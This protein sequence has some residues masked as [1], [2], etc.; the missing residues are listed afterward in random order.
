MP[1]SIQWFHFLKFIYF[2]FCWGWF[3]PFTLWVSGIKSRSPG[4]VQVPFL[5]K[6]LTTQFNDFFKKKNKCIE[7]YNHYN[8][9]FET[10]H[11]S[12]LKV[13]LFLSIVTPCS[14]LKPWAMPE[15]LLL[16]KFAYS[17]M[18][19]GYVDMHLGL[20]ASRFF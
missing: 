19:Y 10:T 17:G 7:L 2:V 1:S 4:L 11:L 20:F 5:T 13:S 15:L 8:N 9:P 16:H 6:R 14:C 12:P 3:S 18:P